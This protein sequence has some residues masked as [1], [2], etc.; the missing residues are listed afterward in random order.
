MFTLLSKFCFL[1][2]HIT[3]CHTDNYNQ[4]KEL[5]LQWDL[6]ER[7]MNNH[8]FEAFSANSAVKED[9]LS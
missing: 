1:N 2:E 3:I 4:A 9:S 6:G 8:F 7:Q 5:Y